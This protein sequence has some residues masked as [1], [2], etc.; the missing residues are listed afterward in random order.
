MFD[1]RPISFES[2]LYV[3]A[4]TEFERVAAYP[5]LDSVTVSFDITSRSQIQPTISV[6]LHWQDSPAK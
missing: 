5:V 6:Q 1:R 4:T 2:H 3:T